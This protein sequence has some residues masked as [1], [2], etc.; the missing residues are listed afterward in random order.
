MGQVDLLFHL[1]QIDDEI[2][3][4][5]KR[6]GRILRLQGEDPELLSVRERAAAAANELQKLRASQNESNLELR[7]L[8]SKVKNSERRL[9]SGVVKNPKELSDLQSEIESLSRRRGLL[10]DEILEVMILAEEAEEEDKEASDSLLKM[11]AERELELQ[12]LESEKTS[13]IQRIN[14][15]NIE[16]KQQI[17]LISPASMK[18]YEGTINRAGLTAVVL[19]KGERCRGCQVTV[20]ANLVKAADEGQLVYCD[21]CGRILSPL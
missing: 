19:L 11:E 6:L 16:R 5:K 18:A 4:G 12:A 3:D 8:N 2:R 20:P 17:A 15:L 14:D 7:G 1:Q 21:S 10:E 13:L 9:Y